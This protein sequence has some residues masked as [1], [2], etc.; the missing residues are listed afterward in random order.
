MTF[1]IL[2]DSIVKV[3]GNN[4]EQCKDNERYF[5]LI[6]CYV[7]FTGLNQSERLTV[8]SSFSFTTSAIFIRASCNREDVNPVGTRKSRFIDERPD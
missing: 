4:Q 7:L 5:N 3:K 8:R 2:Q 1:G 6:F